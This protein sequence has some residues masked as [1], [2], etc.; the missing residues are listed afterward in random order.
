[1]SEDPDGWGWR[2]AY[3]STAG[4]SRGTVPRPNQDSVRVVV[5]GPAS[6]EGDWSAVV[7]AVA[8]GHGGSPHVRSDRGS[9]YAVESAVRVFET[10]LLGQEGR[11]SPS[12]A[13]T[14]SL[15]R[16]ILD[17]WIEAV[18]SDLASN[19]LTIEELDA[20]AANQYASRTLPLREQPLLAY[21]TTIMVVAVNAFGDWLALQVGDG[22]I[23]RIG[24]ND[25]CTR[26]GRVAK[27]IS[28]NATE[29]LCE[30]RLDVFRH[31]QGF[32]DREAVAFVLL[33]DGVRNSWA[34][35]TE[36]LGFQTHVARVVSRETEPTASTKL[37]DWA[38]K[39][40]SD[41]AGDD[42]TIACVA[43]PDGFRA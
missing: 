35:E 12:T 9:R 11:W 13:F 2:K 29:S 40:A 41:G 7:L 10:S 15:A 8:D 18:N 3:A 4:A 17:Q 22:D 33:S 37:L 39:M 38:T 30:R 24:S 16:K 28:S 1:M 31:N 14:Q 5:R 32:G 21:G 42:T 26:V 20:P 25:V 34:D 36:F 23:V 19:A 6:P 43:R 27:G